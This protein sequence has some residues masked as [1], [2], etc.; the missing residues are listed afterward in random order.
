MEKCTAFVFGGGGSRGALQVGAMRALL[1]ADMVPD[2]LVGTSIGA[3]NAAGLALWG[4]D[5][6]GLA[7]LERAWG[8][9]SDLQVLD[10][11]VSGLVLRALLG[12]PSDRTRKKV[13]DFFVSMGFTHDLRFDQIARVRLALISADLETGQLVVYGRDRRESILEGL[14][15]SIALPP[16]F[17]PLHKGGQLI[18]DG[19]ALSN[20]PIELALRLGATEIVA[21][22]LD[23]AALMPKE[24]RTFSQYFEKYLYAL[25]RRHVCLEMALAEAQG[26]SVYV[27]E[28]RG[29][30]QDPIWDFTH[31]CALIRAGYEKANQAMAEWNW[32]RATQLESILSRPGTEKLPG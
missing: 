31:Y 23:D 30:A 13:E 19:G 21:F 16:W 26:V 27:I 15:A 3:V 32:S 2:L 9:V 5:L 22:D 11:R 17:A 1:E 14:L 28:F 12:H 25:S 6:D 4:V 18:V 10:P 7:A 24:N 20:L 8:K 29:L